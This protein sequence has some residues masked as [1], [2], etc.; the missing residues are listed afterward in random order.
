MKRLALATIAVLAGCAPGNDDHAGTSLR[1]DAVG[2]LADPAGI[3]RQLVLGATGAGLTAADG[4]GRIVP[5]LA[6]SWRIAND[7]RSIIFRLRAAVWPDGSPVVATDI[8]T[9]LRRRAAP[10]SPV[11]AYL[12]PIENAAAIGRSEIAV[13]ALGVGA[14]VADVVEIRLAAPAAELLAALALPDLAVRRDPPR[15]SGRG[16]L[17]QPGLGAFDA[18]KVATA[19]NV[20]ARPLVLQRNP[21]YHAL[22]GGS[23]GKIALLPVDDPGAAISDFAHNRADLVVGR[24][25]AGLS[26]A[27]LLGPQVLHV[28][29]TWGVYGYLAN[30][31]RGP[32]AD[33]RVRRALAMAVDRSSLGPRLFGLALQPV[34]GLLP[35][36]M[37]GDPVPLLPDWAILAPAGRVEQARA[38]L[39]A[40][41][42]DTAHPLTLAVSLPPGREHSAVLAAVAADW[43]AIGV[44]ISEIEFAPKLLEAAIKR[45]DFELALSE[46]TVPV[47]TPSLLLRRFRCGSNSGGYCNPAADAALAR[48]AAEPGALTA[49]VAAL[50]AD[51]PLIPLFRPVRWALVR[52]NVSGWVNN[53]AGQHPLASLGVTDRRQR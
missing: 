18:A 43:R 4:S 11:R 47:D 32:L 42:Y 38:L 25:L 13:T 33:I 45:G 52:P 22:T 44:T 24:D 36:G 29:P 28:E 37:A 26:D 31:R 20:G 19:A 1:V 48:A 49:A 7:G 16:D 41:G 39:A 30:V 10:A 35:L 53:I 8:V 27:R 23:L 14:P 6:S 3:P 50:L 12:D 40:A 21:R 17:L 9:L 46:T 34:D 5:G 15:G 2:S 51:P